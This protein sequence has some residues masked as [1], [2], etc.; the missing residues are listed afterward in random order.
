MPPTLE[1]RVLYLLS[2][3]GGP[4][5]GGF[6]NQKNPRTHIFQLS[7]VFLH[8]IYTSMHITAQSIQR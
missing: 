5:F 7:Y 4:T 8:V 6:F 2:R 1:D 3:W